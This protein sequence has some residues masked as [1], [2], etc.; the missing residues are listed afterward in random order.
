MGM[1]SQASGYT[2]VGDRLADALTW[3]TEIINQ[4]AEEAEAES[5]GSSPAMMRWRVLAAGLRSEPF[6][7]FWPPDTRDR[8][9]VRVRFGLL[10]LDLERRLRTLK[11]LDHQVP[12]RPG[13]R[14][15]Q[16]D[17]RAGHLALD[18]LTGCLR[19]HLLLGRS[20]Q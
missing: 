12:A 11:E 5:S 1:Y 18:S 15:E 20:G 19:S 16:A 17:R 13:G 6:V 14:A 9:L 4:R 8:D 10:R 7:R 3:V 2:A